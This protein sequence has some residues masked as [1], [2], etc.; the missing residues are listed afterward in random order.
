MSERPPKK[1]ETLEVR[2]PHEV[3]H[4]LMQK[5]RAEGRSVSEVV[6][7]F[8]ADYLDGDRK[9]ASSMT[10]ALWKPAAVATLSGV[11]VFWAALVPSA[12]NAGPDLTAA[13]KQLDQNE[14][15]LVSL[16]EF[17]RRNADMLFL[18]A[19]VG[20]ASTATEKPFVIPIR[21]DL[22]PP[23][24]GSTLPPRELLQL[25]FARH[26]RNNDG[27]VTLGEFQSSHEQMIGDG[28]N[29]LDNDGD[30][31]LSKAEYPPAGSG[32]LGGV[33]PVGFELL[34]RDGDGRIS[35]E[36]FVS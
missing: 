16:S 25:E 3:K 30:G 14:D 21:R 23:P 31:E 5:A 26:D 34:D 17:V 13:F 10:F 24:A 9:E 29:A 12:A 35:K 4:A 27:N 36:E 6:R 11:A 1:T 32:T 15:G 7:T 18:Q 2:V 20:D 33:S 19:P 8:I 22:P 28:F